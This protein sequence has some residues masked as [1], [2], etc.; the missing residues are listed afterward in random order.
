MVVKVSIV[1][2]TNGQSKNLR[3]ALLSLQKQSF[4]AK[5]YEVIV[6]ENGSRGN[7]KQVVEE[8][9]DTYGN[10]VGYVYEP[11][12]GL[13]Y[14]RNTGAKV[15]KGDIVLYTDDDVTTDHHWI[16]EIYK[17]YDDPNV[18]AVGGKIVGGWEVEPPE[19]VWMFGTKKNIYP[20]TVIDLGEGIFELSK[21]YIVGANYSARK[22]VIFEVGGSNPD[23]FPPH[24]KYL[25]GDG[26]CGFIDKV[27]AK[28]YKV[29]YNSKAVIEHCITGSRCTKEY[30]IKR[31]G[32]EA[33]RQVYR[34]YRNSNG[35][36]IALAKALV[37]QILSLV[38]YYGKALLFQPKLLAIHRI[39]LMYY[40]SFLKHSICLV[41]SKSLKQHTLQKDY[42]V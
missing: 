2:P 38:K 39:K 23:M 18:G 19:W 4:S 14:G 17:C 40:I 15:A 5:E 3:N 12:P 27:R 42:M 36:T 25:N 33:I 30:F 11:R 37:R 8:I 29:I 16:E 1:I 13:H 28:G 22:S 35:S 31:F 6:V 32:D 20:L 24:L 26:E 41:F 9:N 7:A 10:N 34:I 21:G